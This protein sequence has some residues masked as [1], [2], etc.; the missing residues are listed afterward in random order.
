MKG[1]NMGSQAQEFVVD[2]QGKKK[3]IL[4]PMKKYQKLMM[5][6]H[7]LAVV[8]ERKHEKPLSSAAMK[9]RLKHN[10]VI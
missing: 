9:K 7:D 10:D 6:L 5:D 3:A 1:V 2:G 4:L 8:A